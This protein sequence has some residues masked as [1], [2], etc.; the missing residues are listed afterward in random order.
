MFPEMSVNSR[1][2]YITSQKTVIV[3]ATTVRRSESSNI[4]YDKYSEQH[5][6]FHEPASVGKHASGE[7]T[8]YHIL[9]PKMTD[10]FTAEG[11]LFLSAYPTWFPDMGLEYKYLLCKC[12]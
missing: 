4:L 3:S 1:Q 6:H 12:L 11:S 7:T 2:H 9:S 10:K 8:C 5:K